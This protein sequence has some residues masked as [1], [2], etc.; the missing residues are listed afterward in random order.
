MPFVNI[1]VFWCCGN[2]LDKRT[3]VPHRTNIACSI[4]GTNE[5]LGF[6]SSYSWIMQSITLVSDFS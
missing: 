5:L 6:I 3:D 2:F 4:Y 1:T